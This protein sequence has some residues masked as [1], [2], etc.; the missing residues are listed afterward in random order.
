MVAVDLTPLPSVVVDFTA[1][2][3]AVAAD[4]EAEHQASCPARDSRRRVIALVP[5]RTSIAR[6][7]AQQCRHCGYP[8]VSGP[9][10]QERRGREQLF[11]DWHTARLANARQQRRR[12]GRRRRLLRTPALGEAVANRRPVIAWQHNKPA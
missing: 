7:I 8:A 9:A 6:A 12:I 4:L 5:S 11:H 1:V 3:L 2:E 10:L